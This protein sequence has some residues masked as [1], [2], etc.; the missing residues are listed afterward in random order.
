MKCTFADHFW[1]AVKEITGCKLPQ[2]HPNTWARDLLTGE[3]CS[4]EEV[5]LFICGVW[6]LWSGRNARRHG[7][8]QWNPRAA[9]RHIA[10]M[11]EDMICLNAKPQVEQPRQRGVWR[12]PNCG[13]VKVNTD[14][15]FVVNLQKGSAGVVIRDEM[16]GLLMASSKHYEHI[17]DVFNGRGRS[18]ERWRHAASPS[19]WLREGGAGTR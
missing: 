10:T 16:G 1:R 6:S 18:G 19:R 9:A 8:T 14:A 7:R 13:W 5:A 11:I 3:C 17:P 4:Q 12:K 15:S 2:L